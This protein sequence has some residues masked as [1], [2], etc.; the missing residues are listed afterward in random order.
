M[1]VIHLIAM[2]VLLKVKNTSKKVAWNRKLDKM[3]KIT[4]SPKAQI[5]PYHRDIVHS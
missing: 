2:P 3:S 4:E 1:K 5:S